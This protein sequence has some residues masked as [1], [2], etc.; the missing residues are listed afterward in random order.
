MAL[1]SRSTSRNA[2][3]YA[4][5]CFDTL[6][7]GLLI[8]EGITNVNLDSMVEIFCIFSD[9]F[10]LQLHGRP[11]VPEITPNF[12]QAITSSSLMV[13]PFRTLT[14]DTHSLWIGYVYR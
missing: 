9:T 1:F 13:G 11:L 10:D 4:S 2:H 8:A 12:N 6:L 14:I 3:I 5:D 7:G